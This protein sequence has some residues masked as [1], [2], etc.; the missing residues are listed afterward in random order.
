LLFR[1]DLGQLA[2]PFFGPT[3]LCFI[4][5]ALLFVGISTALDQLLDFQLH[6][7]GIS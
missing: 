5:L 1:I 6:F 4:G 7:I 2:Q 3:F